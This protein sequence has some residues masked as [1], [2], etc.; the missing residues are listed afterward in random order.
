MDTF[1]KK[2]GFKEDEKIK[3]FHRSRRLF[4]IYNDKLFVAE[5]AL[6]YSHASWFEKEGWITKENDSLMNKIVRGIVDDKEDIYFYVGYDFNVN[7]EAESSFFPHLNELSERLKL[8]NEAK[9]FG[10]L[11]KGDPGKKW[12]AIKKYGRIKDNLNI[13]K[14]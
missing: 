2:Y 9:I 10:G 8:N 12:P 1:E 4:A 14:S 3:A 6:P 5:P 13:K 7:S 11:I